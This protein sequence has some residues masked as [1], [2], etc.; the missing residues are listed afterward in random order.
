MTTKDITNQ[1]GSC[2]APKT[3]K[4]L[5]ATLQFVQEQLAKSPP[6]DNAACL[7]I[8]CSRPG[9]YGVAKPLLG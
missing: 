5:Q 7:R 4:P 1:G 9:R 2:L 8:T 6:E 3:N